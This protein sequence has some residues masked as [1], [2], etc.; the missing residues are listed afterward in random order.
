ML[1]SGVVPGIFTADEL[2]KIR[3]ESRR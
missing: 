2:T 1:N 3:D